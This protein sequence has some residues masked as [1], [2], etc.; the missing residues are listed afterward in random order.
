MKFSSKYCIVT[1]NLILKALEETVTQNPK[2]TCTCTHTSTIEN[3]NG[4]LKIT[5]GVIN[6]MCRC[7]REIMAI[8]NNDWMLYREV[9]S[10]MVDYY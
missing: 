3:S 1:I 7:A 10:V 5:C 2:I 6:L 8:R 4:R 9:R